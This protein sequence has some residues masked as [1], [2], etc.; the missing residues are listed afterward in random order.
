MLM[1][2]LKIVKP[3]ERR[4]LVLAMPDPADRRSRRLE[5]T[6]AGRDLLVEA[7]PIWRTT[8]DEIDRLTKGADP[9]TICRVL[10][11]LSGTA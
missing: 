3:L 6:D 11:D 2:V 9:E 10:N 8:H 7:V 5:L 1:P 4:G